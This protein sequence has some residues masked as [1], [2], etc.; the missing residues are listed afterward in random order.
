MDFPWQPF[1]TPD[2]DAEL[3]GVIGE[4]RPARYRTVPRVLFSTRRIAAQLDESAG[5]VGYAFRAEFVRRRFW[6]VSAWDGA[7]ALQRFIGTEPHAAVMVDLVD[8]LET[9][10]FD[11]FALTGAEVPLGIDEAIARTR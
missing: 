11:R 8:T 3:L 7:D 5:L 6:A 2:P 9:S 4:I 10:Q 1:A